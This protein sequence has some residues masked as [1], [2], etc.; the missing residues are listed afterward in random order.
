MKKITTALLFVLSVFTLVSCGEEKTP[1]EPEKFVPEEPV[2][3]E[4]KELK[5]YDEITNFYDNKMIMSGGGG[6]ADPFMLRYNG[7][8]YLYMTTGGGGIMAYKSQDML[9]WEPVDN[10]ITKTGYCYDYADDVNP[11]SS[12]TPYAPEVIHFNGKFY[13]IC[14]PSGNGHYVLESDSPEGPFT[15]I[16]DN[17]G[18]SID[19][20]HFIDGKDEKIYLFTAGTTGIRGYELEDDMYTVKEDEEGNKLE[21]FYLDCLVGNWTEGPYMLQ[22]NGNYYFTY[23]GTHFLSASYRVNYAYADKDSDI[24]SSK[25]LTEMD[26]ILLSTTDDFRGLGHSSTVLGPDMDSYYIVYHNL[27]R[28]NNRNLNYS[29]LSFNGSTMVADAVQTSNIPGMDLPPFYAYD[30]T[31]LSDSDDMLLSYEKTSDVFSAEFNVAGEGKMVFSYI[32]EKNYSYIEF[33]DNKINIYK[34]S[35]G[36]EELVHS[37]ALIREYS[38]D[39]IHTFRLQYAKGKLSL[40]FDSMEK[41][42][43]VDCY[44]KGGKI[45]YFKDNDFSEIGYTAFSNVALGSSDSKSYNTQVSLANAYDE[46]LSYLT[47]GSCLESTGT[48]NKYYINANSNNLIIKNEGNRATYRTY[49]ESEI[50]SIEMRLPSKYAGAKLGIRI[51]DEDIK[52]ISIPNTAST[53]FKDGDIYVSLGLFDL[54]EGQ[55]NISIYNIGEEI[56]YSE[57]RYV[58]V[59]DNELDVTFDESF[60]KSDF[61]TKG[62]LNLTSNGFETLEQNVCG[63]ISKFNYFN[64]EIEANLVINTLPDAGYVG[65][66]FNSN[67]YSNYPAADADGVDFAYPYCGYLISFNTD[68]ILFK[69]VEFKNYTTIAR[70]SFTYTPGGEINIKIIQNNNNYIVYINGE[71]YFNINANVGPLSGGVGVFAQLADA[72]FK[73]LSVITN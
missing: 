62:K 64:Y 60:D 28:S 7:Y 31:E 26:T 15:Q 9:Y 5:E 66:V 52:E 33:I 1:E 22:R 50:Y 56:G 65:V 47:S 63:V 46:R 70:K 73:D 49:L 72:S 34:V 37:V 53:K 18:L 3:V 44:F 21:T 40:Y 38:T 6:A 16:S 12:Q 25:S 30:E 59:Y 68:E 4:D 41:A 8:Y 42:Y 32:D 51:D 48:K 23:T 35:K 19:G 27:E 71:E 67:A 61:F 11:P 45:G 54:F 20:H 29:R 24:F 57:I 43:D 14:S 10:G 17:I 55:H 69:H 2:L 39:V 58:K 36:E 13:M